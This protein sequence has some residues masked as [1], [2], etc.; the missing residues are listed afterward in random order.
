MWK[1]V[2]I[3]SIV[4]VFSVFCASV[5]AVPAFPGAEGAGKNA[6]G[7]R[8]G[9]VY[10]VTTLADSGAGSFR[11]AVTNYDVPRIVV[12][13]VSGTINLSSPVTMSGNLTVAGQTAPG[14]GITIKGANVNID[15]AVGNTIVRY[16]RVRLGE[17]RHSESDSFDIMG[18]GSIILDHLSTSWSVDEV[19]SFPMTPYFYDVTV[20]WCM[21]TEGLNHTVHSKGEHSK[22]TLL[23]GAEGHKFSFHH[24]IYAHNIDRNPR[25]SGLYQ[26]TVDPC[27]LVFDFRNNVL[28][29]WGGSYAGH[30]P[31][32]L[33]VTHLNFVGNYYKRGVNSSPTSV[34]WEERS[35][36]SEGYF[37]DNWLDG[38]NPPDRWSVVRFVGLTAE[39]I[40]AYK[41]SSEIPIAPMPT[42]DALTAYQ[43]VLAGAG[44]TVPYRDSVDARVVN[45]INTGTGEVID[46]TE[47]GDFYW[48]IAM[49]RGGAST[50]ITL[51]T[52]DKHIDDGLNGYLIDILSGTGSGQR[53]TIVDYVLS[54]KIATVSP[55]WTTIPDTTSEYG[56]FIDCTKNAGGYP[57]LNSATPPVDT[58]HDGMPDA[59]EIAKG[60]NLNDANDGKLDRDSDGYT[61]VE[62]YLNYLAAKLTDFPADF[63]KDGD[64]D[65]NDL[66][67]FTEDWLKNDCYNVPR[68]NMDI[69]CDVDFKDY[70]IFADYWLEVY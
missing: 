55:A 48:P 40:A 5:N 18:G 29:N 50:T 4:G 58:D 60:L 68:R 13:R 26:Y 45:E 16:I 47:S 22:G 19:L 38:V 30:C 25:L 42:D 66:D 36:H 23:Y 46:C 52:T 34:P 1:K 14:D 61:N 28:Y 62:E 20:Q 27:G 33:S 43:K 15:T 37:N 54:T 57:V 31:A 64:V 44:C 65:E 9:T 69:D 56:I 59:W 10:E 67:L 17:E 12:F 41:R 21:I 70:A 24:N 32:A 2:T 63:D 35:L 39:Q 3:L 11:D 8:G 53:R 51:A 6:T 49:A 7:G